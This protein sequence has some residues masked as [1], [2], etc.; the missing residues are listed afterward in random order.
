MG[1]YSGKI[2]PDKGYTAS[3]PC[4]LFRN[5]RIMNPTIKGK[6][7][8]FDKIWKIII[9]LLLFVFVWFLLSN[10]GFGIP[11]PESFKYMLQAILVF[12]GAWL[13]F[14]YNSS[15]DKKEEIKKNVASA[16]FI[17]FQLITSLNSVNDIYRDFILQYEKSPVRHVQIQPGSPFDTSSMKI[18]FNSISFLFH[19]N[20]DNILNLPGYMKVNQ[21][22]FFNVEYTYLK[23]NE[24]YI[25]V[26]QPLM[27]DSGIVEGMTLDYENF[28]KIVGVHNNNMLFKLT[29][30]LI[31]SVNISF[32]DTVTIIP[33]F[34]KAL[35][36]LFPNEKIIGTTE[37]VK[38]AYGKAIS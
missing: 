3:F 22:H 21:G 26:I 35:D 9:A 33:K 11:S 15:R 1:G 25:T 29:N 2:R 13:A 4:W 8:M 16:N 14:Q 20:D 7:I 37:I 36:K 6:E 28:Q 10:I 32:D 30:D 24:F 12:I 34:K 17:Q 5:N 18:D 19:S 27:Q 31:D 23:R 38:G